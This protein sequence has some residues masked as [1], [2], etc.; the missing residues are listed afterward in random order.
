MAC[1]VVN[2]YFYVAQ[3]YDMEG[4][5]GITFRLSFSVVKCALL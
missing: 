3:L 5:K 1:A 4:I 2:S